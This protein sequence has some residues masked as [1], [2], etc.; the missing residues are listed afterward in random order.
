MQIAQ[1]LLFETSTDAALVE[2]LPVGII[3]A[4]QQRT[5]ADAL[6]LRVGEADHHELAV[7]AAFHLQ[8]LMA[9]PV[10]IG[11]VGTLADNAFQALLTGLLVKCRPVAL[12]MIGIAYGTGL[13]I[14][15]SAAQ[16][17][18]KHLLA[19]VLRHCRQV[20][21]IQ[22]QQIKSLIHHASSVLGT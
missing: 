2:Q 16:Q 4:E 19:L 7:A 15:L 1:L 13:A 14:V 18:C 12:K 17:L 11:A 6:T 10:G 8:P 20:M 9:A 21:A 3:G 22:M 5:E